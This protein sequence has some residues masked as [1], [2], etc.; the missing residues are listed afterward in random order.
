M[1]DKVPVKVPRVSVLFKRGAGVNQL[2][3]EVCLPC[4]QLSRGGL[5]NLVQQSECT[6]TSSI[7]AC[8]NC[9]ECD[10]AES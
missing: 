1:E 4:S 9:L 5:V 8:L 6:A 3:P 2:D 7:R 10:A